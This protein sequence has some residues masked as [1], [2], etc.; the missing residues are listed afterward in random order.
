M[1][2]RNTNLE[3]ETQF[4]DLNQ[5]LKLEPQTRSQDANRNQNYQRLKK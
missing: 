3:P 2:T 5:P 4:Q 1:Q